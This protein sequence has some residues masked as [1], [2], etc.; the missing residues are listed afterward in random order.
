MKLRRDSTEPNGRPLEMGARDRAILELLDPKFRFKYLP[1]NWV[2]AFIGGDWTW[3]RKRLARMKRGPECYL[4]RPKQQDWSENARYKHDV[5]ARS[6][7]GAKFLGT[8]NGSKIYK[9]REYAHD[10]LTD[11]VDASIEIGVRND[12]SL[13]LLTWAHLAT[14]P[15][16]PARTRHAEHPFRIPLGRHVHNKELFLEPDGRPLIIEKSDNGVFRKNIYLLKEID[17]STEP[18]TSATDRASW[19]R[20]LQRYKMFF[21]GKLYAAHYGFSSCLVLVVTTSEQRMNAMLAMKP[22]PYFL[23]RVEPNYARAPRFPAPGG[24]MVTEPWRRAGA[25]EFYLNNP[26]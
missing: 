16:V 15:N 13:R 26:T 22:P 1:S 6:D 21:D 2:H 24:W 23:F 14:H 8:A 7:A 12:P 19:Q 18:L 9:D 25:A 17:L 5:Y 4:V 3:L 20:K 10:L 11:L